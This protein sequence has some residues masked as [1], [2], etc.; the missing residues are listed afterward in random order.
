MSQ[1]SLFYRLKSAVPAFILFLSLSPGFTGTTA[2]ADPAAKTAIAPVPLLEKGHQVDWWFVFKFN[3]A[4]FQGC[5]N[6]AQRACPFGGDV[7]DYQGKFS[8]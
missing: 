3:V 1:I 8:Q 2:F 4:S 7:Q 6:S 5:G